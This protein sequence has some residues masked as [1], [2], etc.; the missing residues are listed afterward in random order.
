M[1]VFRLLATT[2]LAASAIC[3]AN[4]VSFASVFVGNSVVLQAGTSR[5]WGNASSGDVVELS[6][7]GVFAG[8][9]E[10]NATGRWE[11]SL[12]HGPSWSSD[13]RAA[14]GG[15]AATTTV[16]FGLVMLCSGQSNM[17]LNLVQLANGTEE[18]AAAGAYTGRISLMSLQ[19]PEKT[20]PPWNGTAAAP[21]WNVVSPGPDGTASPFSGLCWLTG[22]A[23]FEA[24]AGAVPVGLISAAVGGTPIEAWLPPGVLG[25]SCP[26]DDP[27]CGGSPDDSSLW[28]AFVAPFA[29]LAVGATLWD[30]GERDVH[31][32]PPATNRTAQA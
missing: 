18:A 25:T 30:Q 2:A 8:R 4:G 13:I 26:S 27:P 6:I 15:S 11:A 19:A 3:V 28:A 5:V 7:D 21:Q 9:V 16:R 1:P 17:Q 31:C 14:V 29:P 32:I 23:L 20:Q 10:T 22:K 24:W 12:T